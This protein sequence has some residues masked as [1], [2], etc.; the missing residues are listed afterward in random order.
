MIGEQAT[1]ACSCAF[2]GGDWDN[3]ANAG[4]F[5]LN[6]N[7]PRSNANTNIGGR[8]ALLFALKQGLY[9]GL[10][11]AKAKGACFPSGAMRRKKYE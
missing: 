4:V 10:A 3:G 9:D 5:A 1:Q 7:N 2:R 8:P 6:F 11:Q